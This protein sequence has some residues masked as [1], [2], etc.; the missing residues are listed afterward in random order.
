MALDATPGSAT[1]NAYL[2]VAEADAYFAERLHAGAWAA[3]STADK[4]A[5]LIQAT[6]VIDARLCF[7]GAAADGVQALKW[8]RTGL[9]TMNGFA[10]AGDSIPDQLKDAVC[11]LALT[12]LS[13]DATLESEVV[14]QGIT[15]VKAGSVELGFDAAKA[16]L[17]DV[18]KHVTEMLVPAWLCPARPRRATARAGVT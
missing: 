14:A 11:E 18:P 5:A 10:L 3:A 6:R 1:A 7:R 4:E 15:R 16:K 9:V 17:R 13:G 12:L 2:T 8:P